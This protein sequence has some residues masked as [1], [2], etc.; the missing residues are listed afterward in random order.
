MGLLLCTQL[1]A[2]EV[3]LGDLTC[4]VSLILSHTDA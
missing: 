4:E 3:Y 2:G 1:S